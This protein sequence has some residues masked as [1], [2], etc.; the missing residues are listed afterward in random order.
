[1]RGTPGS[2]VLCSLV[3]AAGLAAT[4]PAH[5]NTST[6]FPTG[7]LIIPV[8]SAFQ[9]DCGSMSAYG[10][11]YH[12]LRANTWLAANGYTAITVFY[13]YLD[14]KGS[15]NRCVPT[16]LD[17]P[18]TASVLWNDGCDIMN[19]GVLQIDN[20]NH[21]TPDAT[22]TSF[23]T[24]G[25]T[26]VYPQFPSRVLSG[27]AKANYLGGPF[28]ILA[29]DAPTFRKLLDN[30][31]QAQDIS[32]NIIDF[33]EFR[34][35]NATQTPAP[36]SGC[37]KGVDHYV[38]IHRTTT[39]FIANIGKAF[40][41][42]PPRLALLATNKLGHTSTIS[43]NILQAYLTN[44]GLT[45]TGANGCP[46]GSVVAGDPTICPSG[47]VSGQIYDSFDF[48]DLVNDQLS[49][50]VAGVPLYTMLWTPH[51]EITHAKLYTCSASVTSPVA[52]TC[53]CYTNCTSACSKL[54][55]PGTCTGS[56][57]TPVGPPNANE[58]L[59][60]G[61]ISSFL[62]GQTGLAAECA[63]VTSYEGDYTAGAAD[64]Q[65]IPQFQTCLDTGV[66]TCAATT[67]PWGI[68]RNGTGSYLASNVRNCSDPNLAN[69][70]QCIFYAY[71]GDSFAQTGDY[72]F[73]PVIGHT[74]AWLP[75]SAVSS[76]YRPGVVPLISQV[77]LSDSTKIVTPTP[78][79]GTA[80]AAATAIRPIVVADLT[81][82][83]VK[84]NTAG[85]AN[86]LY[87]A[88]HDEHT[89]VAGTKVMLETLLQLGIS[90]LPPIV[91]TVEVSRNSPI[92]ATIDG[93]PAIVQGTFEFI[94]SS[95]TTITASTFSADS[96][97]STFR[98]PFT[99]GHLRARTTA[100]ITTTSSGFNTGTAVFDASGGIPDATYTGTGCSTYFTALCRTVF[101]TYVQGQKPDMHF[102]RQTEAPVLGPMM[103]ADL[104]S[105]NQEVLI[106]RIIAGD[107][108]LIPGFFRPALGGVDRSTV[109]IIDTSPLVSSTRPMMAYFGADD[110][111]M[112]AVCMSVAGACDII[113][114]E[115]WAYLPRTLLS[116]VR[117]NTGHIDG[118]PHVIDSFGDFTGSGQRKWS[119]LMFFQTG[120]GDTTGND[121]KPAVYGID[122]SDPANPVVIFEYS[123][124]DVA[125]RGSFELGVG[126]TLAAGRV[127]TGV[128]AKT[129]V[130]VQTNNGGTAGSGDVVIA[131]N[132]ETAQA[133]W[134]AGYAFSPTLRIG[135]TSIPSLTGVPGGA[136]A[137]D[138]TGN[139]YVTDVV[140]GTLYGDVWRADPATGISKDGVG[141]PLFRW[142]T[143]NHPI[144]AKPAI[145]MKGA[146]Q[147]AVITTGGYVD[148]YPNDTNWS[149]V[150]TTNYVLAISMSTPIVDATINENKGTPDISFKYAF[151]ANEK[152]IAQATVIN[153][154]V[155]VTTDTADTN[156]NTNP[157]AYGTTG[158][159]TG[160]VYN[161]NINGA[162]PVL[163]TT[164]VVEGGATSVINSGLGV[165]SGSSDQQSRLA[166]NAVNVVG[167]GVDTATTVGLKRKLWLR[168]Q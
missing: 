65:G 20:A 17:T 136:V 120:T 153:G 166:T 11:V 46:P 71:P 6:A 125:S 162:S 34:T 142:S 107:D 89:S 60:L 163:G 134:K 82:R 4:A 86:I 14:T 93:S 55:G 102:L 103:G 52:T 61:K 16:S 21:L 78:Y 96:D 33:S 135:G 9:D 56:V 63:S 92:A 95:S 117:Y 41:S 112:H 115:L 167:Q 54:A 168:S 39:A 15:P 130:F 24:S 29:S 85:K 68:D 143:D 18:T 133:E 13:T 73:S 38:N 124:A 28:V 126:L 79:N 50:T 148:T 121:R 70:K 32:G 1:M 31:I 91:S 57:T 97:A 27:A 138:K 90:T 150:G 159:A 10:L 128:T 37:S 158:G 36:T 106:Q 156:D 116:T 165:Y 98:Y 83:S 22:V 123:M 84:D 99:K 81:T 25:K 76:I 152:G 151:G 109:A 47:A 7:S 139:G 49:A 58:L 42:V 77:A 67:T 23:K 75:N 100:S 44:A 64:T 53:K 147:Y 140:W 88:G 157:G 66:G 144:G 40:Q 132:A 45:Y 30:T 131:I 127:Q 164:V 110:G 35:R 104:T 114:R 160:H 154:Q 72:S 119:T 108:S 59:A 8:N 5:A 118:S 141:K 155:Y 94:T 129:M 146:T 26:S 3:V 43:N 137:L 19:V 105:P 113:G 62:D 122:I 48:D 149:P 101:T 111:M 12:I 74:Q 2:R 80:S 51:W 69:S 87:L 145:Y 161:I